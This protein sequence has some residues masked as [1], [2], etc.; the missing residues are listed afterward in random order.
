MKNVQAEG[1][2][3][4]PRLFGL[5]FISVFQTVELRDPLGSMLSGIL[6]GGRALRSSAQSRDVAWFITLPHGSS[7]GYQTMFIGGHEKLTLRGDAVCIHGNRLD[8]GL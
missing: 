1:V 3:S 6:V 2:F 5:S 4:A 8:A 7:V